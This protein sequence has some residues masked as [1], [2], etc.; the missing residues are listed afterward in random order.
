LFGSLEELSIEEI[1]QQFETNFFGARRLMQAVIPT[2]R[3]QSTGK[4]VNITSMEEE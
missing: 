2:M 1:K 3:N 4:I